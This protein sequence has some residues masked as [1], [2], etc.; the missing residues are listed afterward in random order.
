MR[1]GFDAALDMLLRAGTIVRPQPGFIDVPN[2]PVEIVRGPTDDA[3]SQR[4]ISQI[5]DSE[6]DLALVRLVTDAIAIEAEHLKV[7]I[8]GLFGFDRTGR[9]IDARLLERIDYLVRDGQLSQHGQTL[10]LP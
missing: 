10:R 8:R 1:W 6:I 9:L 7:R 4:E 2:R 5:A 3:A